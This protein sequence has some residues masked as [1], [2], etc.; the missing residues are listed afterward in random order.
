MK[1]VPRVGS[2]SYPH[3][4]GKIWD[5]LGATMS[6]KPVFTRMSQVLELV[7]PL[8]TLIIEDKLRPREGGVCVP[9]TKMSK[10]SSLPVPQCCLR[11]SQMDWNTLTHE[12]IQH[13][14]TALQ[15]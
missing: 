14:E 15:G 5:H 7:G 11:E 8:T 10:H 12:A 3:K 2:I 13:P 4:C 1:T 6:W 9:A